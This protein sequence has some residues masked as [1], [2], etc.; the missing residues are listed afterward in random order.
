MGFNDLRN[1]LFN[2]DKFRQI[3]CENLLVSLKSQL[4]E[5]NPYNL[6]KLYFTTYRKSSLKSLAKLNMEI[7]KR[8]KSFS[9]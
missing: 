6:Y 2:D 4:S 3:K 5:S 7:A 8:G 9:K 1:K